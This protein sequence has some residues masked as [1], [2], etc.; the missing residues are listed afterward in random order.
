MEV[1]EMWNR[2]VHYLDAAGWGTVA[3]YGAILLGLAI[4]GLLRWLS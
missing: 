3:A 2:G 1:M 4:G